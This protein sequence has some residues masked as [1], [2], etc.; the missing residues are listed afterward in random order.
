MRSVCLILL[1]A[2]VAWA[3]PDEDWARITAMDAGPSQ[4]SEDNVRARATVADFLKLQEQA[5]RSF[6]AQHA[7]DR[8]LL[9]AKLRLAHLLAVRGDMNSDPEATAAAWRLLDELGKSA[10]PE[11]AA[12]VA[13]ARIALFMQ[14][15]AGEGQAARLLGE[16]QSFANRF[17]QDRRLA[18]LFAETALLYEAQ[19]AQKRKLLQKALEVCRDPNLEQRVRDDL[20]RLD[21]ANS[22]LD[23]KLELLD[24][25]TVDL[26]AYRGKLVLICFFAQ[27]SPPSMKVLPKVEAALQDIGREKV[28]VL[29]ISLDKDPKTTSRVLKDLRI[30]WPVS[31]QA[32]GWESPL[33]RSLGINALPTLWLVDRKG[34]L[35]PLRAQWDLRKA[36]EQFVR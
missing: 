35:H 11:R 7:E 15:R 22:P 19:P 20:K 3:G 36:I 12:D 13:F 28:Q 27:W 30:K 8:R 23:L 31:L 33:V 9:D 34:F 14:T 2:V 18:A 10:P 4:L 16:I 25:Q 32:S 26:K 29:G 17:P 5:L 6:I 24:G 1:L 21:L